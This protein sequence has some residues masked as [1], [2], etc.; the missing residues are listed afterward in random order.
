MKNPPFHRGKSTVSA[1]LR[2]ANEGNKE[3]KKHVIE[4]ITRE[5]NLVHVDAIVNRPLKIIEYAL[6]ASTQNDSG[7]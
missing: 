5:R 6:G 7:H 2:R 1:R 4:Y 3:V